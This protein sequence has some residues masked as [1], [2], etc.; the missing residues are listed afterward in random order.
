MDSSPN[1]E[2]FHTMTVI[3]WT[4]MVFLNIFFFV[5]HRRKKKEKKEEKNNWLKIIK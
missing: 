3:E 1:N 4:I 2:K 5:F